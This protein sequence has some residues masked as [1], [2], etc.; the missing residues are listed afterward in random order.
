MYLECQKLKLGE[1]IC[2]RKMASSDLR[3]THIFFFSKTINTTEW[4]YSITSKSLIQKYTGG[5]PT[6]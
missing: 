6:C 4:K 5:N 2:V 1:G 3:T